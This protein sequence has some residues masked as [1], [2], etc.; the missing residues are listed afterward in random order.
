MNVSS[1]AGIRVPKELLV[2]I[3]RLV[4]AYYTHVP[5]PEDS[6]QMVSFGTS[7][8]RGSSFK[9]SFN[10]THILAICQAISELRR[11]NGV[12]GPLFIGMDTHAL[13]EPALYT[14]IE[15][16]SGNEVEL[17]VQND[18]GYTPTP[19]ISSAILGWNVGS[20]NSLADGVVVTPSHNPPEDGGI[21]YNP[22]SGGPA[23]PELTSQ[24]QLRANELIKKGNRDVKRLPLAS[25]LRKETTKFID[26]VIPYV[27]GLSS[28]LDME[29]IARAKIKI[30]VDPLGGSGVAF[31][32]PIAEMYGLN[33]EILNRYVDPTFSFMTLD[34]DGKIRMDCS[35]PYAMAGLLAA[36]EQYGISFAND[37][38]YDRHGIVTREGLMEPNSYLAVAAHYLCTHRTGWKSDVRI[39]KT[40]VSSSIIDR[41]AD[42]VGRGVYEV[43]VGFKWFVDGL[44]DGSLGFAGE[45]SAGRLFPENGRHDVDDRQ[46]RIHHGPAC[47]GDTGRHGHVSFTLLQET[48]RQI[49][50]TL[51]SA[52][53][54]SRHFGAKSGVDTALSHRRQRQ[55][56]GGGTDPLPFDEG[57]W[58][59]PAD[60]RAQGRRRKR[61]VRGSPLR[62]GRRIQD[63][64]GELPRRG[65]PETNSGRGAG[66]RLSD[67][68]VTS[69]V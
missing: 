37:T 9:N 7:G 3:P 12:Q 13:S 55:G 56:I 62:D 45:E 1:L 44:I 52:H 46:G 28:V 42:S 69:S 61:L 2:S 54:C 50:E 21:K 14:A 64:C 43:P 20:R 27:K 23:S 18:F 66:D 48:D 58:K 19:V 53:G 24:I 39:G 63:I 30:G 59:R 5:D 68:P 17:R 36:K 22:P 47:R 33:L 51:L 6:D 26:Y 41:V 15:V 31:W 34:W 40:L 4:S 49:W 25:A 35:S 57:S 10:E 16:F 65:T 11:R 60:R 29:A 8:H 32:T 38:D 67:H